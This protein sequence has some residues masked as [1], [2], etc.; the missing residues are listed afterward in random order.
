MQGKLATEQAL[1]NLFSSKDGQA[2]LMQNHQRMVI[3]DDGPRAAQAY[4]DD[5]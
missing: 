5:D 3:A 4:L 1:K 2:W